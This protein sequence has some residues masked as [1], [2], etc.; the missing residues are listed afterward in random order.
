MGES[1]VVQSKGKLDLLAAP[2]LPPAEEPVA[3][4]PSPSVWEL[5]LY[6]RFPALAALS[7]VTLG[8]FPSPV[9]RVDLAG[10]GELWIKRDDDNAPIAAGNKVRALEFLLGRVG[11]GD[12]V[13]TAGGE[14]STHVYATAVHAARLGART[15]AVRWR[16]DMHAQAYQVAAAAA[17][18]CAAVRSYRW[19]VV[20]L[21]RVGLWRAGLTVGL[22]GS[23]PGFVASGRRHYVPIGGSAPLGV[24]GHINAGLEL[25]SQVAAGTLPQPTHVVVPLGSGG[26]AAG[27]AIGFGIAGMDATV[28]AVRVA[29]RSVANGIRLHAL[30]RR[31]LRLVRG[32][33]GG[34]PGSFRTAPLWIDHSAY[35]GAYGRPLAAGARAATLFRAL[36]DAGNSKAPPLVLDATYS[37]KAAAVALALAERGGRTTRVLLW[38]TFDGRLSQSS[39][40]TPVECSD[41]ER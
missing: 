30:I 36:Y 8:H 4:S 18:R 33:A 31:T 15:V 1:R 10:V 6:D 41:E 27:L 34:P 9:E 24:L 23:G 5:P 12:V 16:H 37:A 3:E 22:A 28:V 13:L 25:A 14:G 35:G 21:L 20:G 7:R 26:T 29:P 39:H 32:Q 38:S 2:V 40:L 17:A 19:P 11:P